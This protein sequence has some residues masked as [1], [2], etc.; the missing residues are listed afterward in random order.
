M[1]KIRDIAAVQSIWLDYIDRHLIRSGELEQI[2]NKYSWRRVRIHTAP[3]T[4]GASDA[5]GID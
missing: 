5:N 3:W 1:N 2:V 4:M